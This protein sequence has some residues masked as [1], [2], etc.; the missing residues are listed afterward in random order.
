[1]DKH[2]K[3]YDDFVNGMARQTGVSIMEIERVNDFWNG[4]H[5]W[6]AKHLSDQADENVCHAVMNQIAYQFFIGFMKGCAEGY[7]E[8]LYE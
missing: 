6:T 2:E 3:I 1:M 5:N 7:K 8:G 4:E